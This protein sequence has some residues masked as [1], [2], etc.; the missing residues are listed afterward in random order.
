[1]MKMFK[2]KIMFLAFAFIVLVGLCII[3][4]S[5]DDNKGYRGFDEMAFT[6]Q[7]TA[8]I[9]KIVL[10]SSGQ[11]N[12]MVKKG[13]QWRL[14][15]AYQ[16]DDY[17]TD[18]ILA[19]ANKVRVKRAVSKAQTPAVNQT[20]VAS[21]VKVEFFDEQGNAV[22]SFFAGG[23]GNKTLSYFS[24]GDLEQP[25]VMYIPGYT[26][27]LSGIFELQERDL[28]ARTIFANNWL[29]LKR[30]LI[31]Y[32]E[33]PKDKVS[34]DYDGHLFTVEGVANLDTAAMMSYVE[35][36]EQFDAD[37]WVTIEDDPEIALVA[38]KKDMPVAVISTEE[39][40]KSK[41]RKLKVLG[42]LSRE[43]LWLAEVNDQELLLLHDNKVK[44]LLKKSQFFEKK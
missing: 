30:I 19:V 8:L 11:K 21:G 5:V 16:A 15:D 23:N 20:L 33:D 12:E 44:A 36:F 28:R 1:M 14:N 25:Y 35:M 22:Q 17:F 38:K 18:L 7:D 26:S 24:K 40:N 27:Y 29:A 3:L 34:I 39:I 13:G 4:V 41:N 2:N 32:P 42:K 37:A 31:E 10:N 43:N 9:H 6:V